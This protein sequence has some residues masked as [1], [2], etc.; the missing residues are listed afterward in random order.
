MRNL[1][2]FIALSVFLAMVSC[3]SYK[4]MTPPPAE[5]LPTIKPNDKVAVLLV[6]GKEIK[7]MKVQAVGSDSLIG[8]YMKANK[9]IHTAIPN[10]EIWGIQKL[11][12]DKGRTQYL[13][14]AKPGSIL[15]IT[16]KNG[17]ILENLK[18]T[19]VDSEKLEGTQTSRAK[20]PY[21]SELGR[22]IYQDVVTARVIKL[23][24]V[25]TIQMK[26]SDSGKTGWLVVGIIAGSLG[27]FLFVA[28][29]QLSAI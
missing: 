26:V 28:I 18:V 17:E 13:C 4:N 19:S 23:S 12:N 7:S 14:V 21:K 10:T 8:T 27:I 15:R 2:K 5:I 6:D 25:E 11:K 20:L 3:S 1:R 9:K 22:P 16:L 24:D 29:L